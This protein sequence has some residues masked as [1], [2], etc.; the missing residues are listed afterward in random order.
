VTGGTTGSGCKGTTVTVSA[1]KAT[2]TIPAGSAVAIDTGVKS[3]AISSA[4][5]GTGD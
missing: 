1:G 2:V 5:A 4:S 3:S